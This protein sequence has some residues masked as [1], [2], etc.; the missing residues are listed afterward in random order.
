MR[1]LGI[2]GE[3]KEALRGVSI[4]GN[5]RKVSMA[6]CEDSHDMNRDNCETKTQL[7]GNY[8]NA[9]QIY[10]KAV[11]DLTRAIGKVDTVQ[12]SEL[13]LAAE[14]ARLTA[15]EARADLDAHMIE[16]AC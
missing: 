15:Q 13:T 8:Q 1:A 7:V 10:S 16:H 12:H 5:G 4:L 9:S 2:S 3:I 11:A 6:S 14:R